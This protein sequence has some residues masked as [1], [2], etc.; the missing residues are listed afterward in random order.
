MPRFLHLIRWLTVLFTLITLCAAIAWW[1]TGDGYWEPIATTFGV[2]AALF[3]LIIDP[4]IEKYGKRIE[5][6]HAIKEEIE[7]NEDAIRSLACDDF[8]QASGG[9]L[10]YRRLGYSAL[11]HFLNSGLFP[12]TPEHVWWGHVA[13]LRV[14]CESFN[15]ALLHLEIQQLLAP[16][17]QSRRELHASFVSG[18]AVEFAKLSLFLLSDGISKEDGSF[19]DNDRPQKQ[20]LA[21]SAHR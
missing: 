6:N 11:D 20:H 2:F 1:K 5:I 14:Y 16:D 17:P 19:T 12:R 15:A 4:L 7:R 21:L 18:K 8:T 13:P 3:G 10:I 9:G